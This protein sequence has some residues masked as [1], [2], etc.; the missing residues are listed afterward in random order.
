MF[1]FHRHSCRFRY[2]SIY[3]LYSMFAAAEVPTFHSGAANRT[4]TTPAQSEHP[5]NSRQ[6]KPTETPKAEFQDGI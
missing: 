4:Q 2:I 6:D 1:Y 3:Y 5:R